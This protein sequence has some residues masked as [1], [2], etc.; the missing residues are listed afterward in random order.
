MGSDLHAKIE[1]EMA[2]LPRCRLFADLVE[3][4]LQRGE[5]SQAVEQSTLGR[6][7]FVGSLGQ[8]INK[9]ITG[10]TDAD[11]VTLYDG[12]GLGVQDTTIAKSIFDQVVD[13]DTGTRVSFS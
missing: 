11:Q 5:V 12:V 7:C 3:H 13:K 4:S 1:C 2:L 6:D 10:R 8:L 9:K